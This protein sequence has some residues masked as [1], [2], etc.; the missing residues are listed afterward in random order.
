[1]SELYTNRLG[2][3]PPLR[4]MYMRRGVAWRGTVPL[5]T[6]LKYTLKALVT[7]PIWSL[8]PVNHWNLGWKSR[9]RMYVYV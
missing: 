3:Q 4:H 9:A 1:M 7:L 8:V 6:L 5:H 2:G